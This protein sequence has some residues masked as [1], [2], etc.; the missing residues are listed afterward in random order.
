MRDA[1]EN[2][3]RDRENR[4]PDSDRMK[5][6]IYNNLNREDRTEGE[7]DVPGQLLMKNTAAMQEPVSTERIPQPVG[8][9]GADGSVMIRIYKIGGRKE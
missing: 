6:L 9:E 2:L 7:Q 1:P 4:Q 8:D 3:F 5:I